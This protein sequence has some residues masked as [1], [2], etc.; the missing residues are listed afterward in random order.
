[1]A[2]APPAVTA[3]KQVAITGPARSATSTRVGAPAGTPAILAALTVT[4]APVGARMM[5]AGDRPIPVGVMATG[6]A[7]EVVT[8]NVAVTV[9]PAMVCT[10]TGGVV[11]DMSIGATAPASADPTLMAI[12]SPTQI[13]VPPSRATVDRR[14]D[15]GRQIN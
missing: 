12:N 13:T 7:A 6:P 9:W 2:M 15:T 3:V 11:T 5:N 14:A 8:T 4:V 1:M 10:A